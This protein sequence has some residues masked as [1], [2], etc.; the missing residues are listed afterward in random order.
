MQ[1]KIRKRVL[2]YLVLFD[3]LLFF[4]FFLFSFEVSLPVESEK[5]TSKTVYISGAIA[6][7]GMY[8][9][10][11]DMSVADVIRY[12]GGVAWNAD[13]EYVGK[14][15]NLADSV[16]DKQHLH[17]PYVVEEQESTSS[18]I[19]LNSSSKAE[20]DS[21]P[22]I[23]PATAD[24]IIAGRPFSSLEQLKD[25]GGIGESKY[26]EIASLIEL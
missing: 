5:T 16:T 15:L 13:L 1:L 10:S 3:V 19:S 7:P 21:L 8:K 18:L 22:G 25:I 9:F 4:T 26:Q 12:A 6:S 14:T 20:L 2:I 11:S 23:G 24:K 17:I